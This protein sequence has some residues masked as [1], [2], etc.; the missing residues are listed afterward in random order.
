MVKRLVDEAE[1]RQIIVFTHDLVFVNDLN[2]HAANTE[3]VARLTTLRR[4]AAEASK[5][6]GCSY[7]YFLNVAAAMHTATPSSAALG[8]R[9]SSGFTLT[10]SAR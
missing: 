3:R 9:I 8:S 5:A 2:D 4:G 1:N 10:G 6:Q 7:R